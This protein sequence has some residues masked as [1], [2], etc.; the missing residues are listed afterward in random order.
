MIPKVMKIYHVTPIRIGFYNKVC[1]AVA[2]RMKVNSSFKI[3][4]YE[5]WSTQKYYYTFAFVI[6]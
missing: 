2:I 3:I 1:I 5:T 4:I 6:I